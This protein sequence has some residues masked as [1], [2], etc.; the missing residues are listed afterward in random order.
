MVQ[1]AAASAEEDKVRM[2]RVEAKNGLES[3]LY[4]ARNSFRDDKA[5]EMADPALLEKGEAALKVHMEWLDTHQE[6]STET[7]K[8]RQKTAEDE[9]RPMLMAMYA[10]TGV[11]SRGM[12]PEMAEAMAKAQAN[13]SAPDMSDAAPSQPRVEEVD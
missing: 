8:E 10:A 7:Y 9:V 11:P 4:G 5:K 6:E 2:E 13:G 12:T 3:Y 1:E